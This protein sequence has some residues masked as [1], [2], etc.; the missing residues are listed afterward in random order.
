MLGLLNS[1]PMSKFFLYPYSLLSGFL[2]YPYILLRIFILNLSSFSSSQFVVNH[3]SHQCIVIGRRY[4][5]KSFTF[6]SFD[7]NFYLNILFMMK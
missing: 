4:K 7:S 1:F 6:N 3:V 5:V 2:M